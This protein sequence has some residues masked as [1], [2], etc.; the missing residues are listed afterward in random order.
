M[1]ALMQRYNAY[2]A[3]QLARSTLLVAL[4]LTSIVWLTQALRML[5][6]IVNQGVSIRIFLWLTLLVL[7]GLIMMI[8]P[9]SLFCALLFLYHKFR[10]DSELIAFQAAGIDK[11]QL[12]RPAILVAAAIVVIGY[13]VSLYLLPV[14][15]GTF[16]NAQSYLRN[17]Y[18]SVL[19]Q[20]GVFAS[21]A[22]GLTVFVRD[23]DDSGTLH[24]VLV[25]DGRQPNAQVTMMAETAK[26]VETAQGP[27]FLLFNGNRQEMRDGSL[28]LLN[29]ESYMLDINLYVGSMVQRAPDPQ[30]KFIG[31]L[32]TS[33]GVD[34]RETL[35]LRAEA[36]QRLLWPFYAMTLT[37]VALALMLSGEFNRRARWQ[38]N[39]MTACIGALILFT[40]AG[41]RNLMTL[42][43]TFVPLAY[44]NVVVP[45]ILAIFSLKDRPILGEMKFKRTERSGMT[46]IRSS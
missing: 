18:V 21:P 12:S 11:W 2:I 1:S 40:G 23:R 32:F 14:S 3:K 30:E 10:V 22:P 6:F 42:H 43:S 37:L 45:A 44:A 24:G 19:L 41:L 4:S 8:L 46:R 9:I 17:N 39:V 15:Y 5:D 13:S 33:Q 16:R 27:H 7:P 31:E 36:N 34:D 25:H 28:S 26:L 29:F 35:R 38:R 20:E